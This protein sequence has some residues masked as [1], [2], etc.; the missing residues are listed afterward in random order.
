M[1][2]SEVSNLKSLLDKIGW[3]GSIGWLHFQLEWRD[4]LQLSLGLTKDNR[5]VCVCVCARMRVYIYIYI[6]V[7]VCLW[8][9]AGSS[10]C[11]FTCIC[12]CVSV[13]AFSR[14]WMRSFVYSAAIL[15]YVVR[16][17]LEILRWKHIRTIS[18]I[19]QTFFWSLLTKRRLSNGRH[20]RSIISLIYS[21]FD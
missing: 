10:I 15:E 19:G 12:V 14:A 20:T 5:I 1:N 7:C 18:W 11:V 3:H 8:V 4:I 6:C 21:R 2:F 9:G 17:K 13:C 16:L